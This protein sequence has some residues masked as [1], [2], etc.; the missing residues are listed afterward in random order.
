MSRFLELLDKYQGREESDAEAEELARLLKEDEGRA[1]TFYDAMM[2]EV[3]LYESYAGIARIQAAPKRR[4]RLQQWVLAWAVAVSV[5]IGLV[6]LMMLGS[7]MPPPAAPTAPAA[8]RKIEVDPAPKTPDPTVPSPLPPAKRVY[9]EDH[10]EESHRSE[11]ER[12]YQKGLREVE[13]KRAQGKTKEADEKLR[14]IERERDKK[15]RERGGDD[16]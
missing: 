6:A 9:R 4:R 7:P 16:R 3:D 11:A 5:L 1:R 2:L 13:R 15:L 10:E 14:E 8:P 12:E